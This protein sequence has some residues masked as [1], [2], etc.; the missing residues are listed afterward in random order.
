M[1]FSVSLKQE[2]TQCEFLQTCPISMRNE[3]EKRME[4]CQ[5]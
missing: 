4:G 5:V 3:R 1:K 2:F